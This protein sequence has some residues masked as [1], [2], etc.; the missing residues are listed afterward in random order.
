MK[1]KH[2]WKGPCFSLR[3]MSYFNSLH[4]PYDTYVYW[5][6]ERFVSNV[7]ITFDPYP[8]ALV[9]YYVF[10]QKYAY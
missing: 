7:D 3:T 2:V 8:F 4:T 10:T 1:S 5:N 6:E 9:H